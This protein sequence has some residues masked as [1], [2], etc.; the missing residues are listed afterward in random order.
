MGEKCGKGKRMAR[1]TFPLQRICRYY[2]LSCNKEED[3]EI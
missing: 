3:V 2:L 1:Q